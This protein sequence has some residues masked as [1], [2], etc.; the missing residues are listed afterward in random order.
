MYAKN[1]RH[2]RS[3]V[4][5]TKSIIY[6]FPKKFHFLNLNNVSVIKGMKFITSGRLQGKARASSK[7]LIE[8]CVPVQSFNQ[9]ID[10]AKIHAYNILG[11]FGLK[12]WIFKN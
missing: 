5:F 8:G 11:A 1:K 9:N 6:E 2:Q 12:L 10:F 7:S 3:G 4:V